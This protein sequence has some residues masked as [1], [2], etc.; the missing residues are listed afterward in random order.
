MSLQREIEVERRRSSV[1]RLIMAAGG[2]AAAPMV[3][4]GADAFRSES[5]HGSARWG[6]AMVAGGALLSS[7]FWLLSRLGD[8][9][10]VSASTEGVD[11]D[12]RVKKRIRSPSDDEFISALPA[13]GYR[14]SAP[15]Y[16]DTSVR[17]VPGKSARVELS[18]AP[19]KDESDEAKVAA[20]ADISTSPRTSSPDALDAEPAAFLQAAPQPNAYA[21]VVG[22]E[23][24]RNVNATPGARR[25]A[26]SFAGLLEDSLGVPGENIHLLTDEDATRGDVLSRLSWLK[27]N[28]PSDGRI[29][30]YFS[31][32]GAPDVETGASYILPFEGQPETIAYTGLPMDKVLTQ[33]DETKARDVLAFVDSCFS[34]QGERS[35]LPAGA[36][37][38]VPVQQLAPEPKVALFASSGALEIAG[39]AADAEEGLFTQHLLRALGEG[40]ADIDGDG[41]ISLAELEQYVAP[42]V[43]REAQRANRDQ[44]P[45]LTV[46]Q[47][48]GDPNHIILMWGLPRD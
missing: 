38:L 16:A 48:L 44:N 6:M 30:F 47:E 18:T 19:E 4:F 41:Q 45:S 3:G 13:T 12:I 35:S 26:E 10:V 32:H 39:N 2:F 1:S 27:E 42:R 11:E 34:G 29:Y 24:Y 40:R 36:R 37:P 46:S 33:L 14:L 28:V 9:L 21:L 15:E 25:D 22:V 23:K 20:D 5:E 7:S 8:D 31:G 43:S 17:V